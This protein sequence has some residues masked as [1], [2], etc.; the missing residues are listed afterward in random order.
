M[1]YFLISSQV[2]MNSNLCVSCM[3]TKKWTHFFFLLFHPLSP[4][5]TIHVLPLVPNHKSFS[6]SLPC[7]LGHAFTI[8]VAESQLGGEERPTSPPPHP[9]SMC[10]H[11]P[12]CCHHSPLTPPHQPDQ[13]HKTIT[14]IQIRT[15]TPKSNILTS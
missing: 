5:A 6:M 10:V 8:V 13:L 7:F 15:Q 9:T 4:I 12:L 3:F 11:C 1:F 14:S 2:E